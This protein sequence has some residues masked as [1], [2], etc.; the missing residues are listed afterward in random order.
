ME[1]KETYSLKELKEAIRKAT[2]EG[3]TCDIS[4]H[5]HGGPTDFVPQGF[6]PFLTISPALCCITI[7]GS[8]KVFIIDKLSDIDWIVGKL[9]EMGYYSV[10]EINKKEAGNE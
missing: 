6:L 7:D 1:C 10:E 8:T 5:K 4:S 2:E 9:K 3:K